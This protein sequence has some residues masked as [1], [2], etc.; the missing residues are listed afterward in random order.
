MEIDCTRLTALFFSLAPP[1]STGTVLL[2]Q[3][4]E[5]SITMLKI[6]EEML[7]ASRPMFRRTI[8]KLEFGA[9][10]LKFLL[11]SLLMQLCY[12]AWLPLLAFL[13]DATKSLLSCILKSLYRLLQL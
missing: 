13:N 9:L 7:L 8:M 11:P 6:H 1:L 3:G 4:K 12:E 10:I 2:D 5:R